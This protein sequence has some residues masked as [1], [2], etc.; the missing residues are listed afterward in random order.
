MPTQFQKNHQDFWKDRVFV[1]D[2]VLC[3]EAKSARQLLAGQKDPVCS[4]RESP[5]ALLAWTHPAG[6][7]SARAT[8]G[9][10]VPLPAHAFERS[11]IWTPALACFVVVMRCCCAFPLSAVRCTAA[12]RLF[13]TRSTSSVCLNLT[14]FSVIKINIKSLKD[15]KTF[16][17]D[18]QPTLGL[19]LGLGF[20]VGQVTRTLTLLLIYSLNSFV[21]R[22]VFHL[23]KR[24]RFKR[25]LR[26]NELSD[27]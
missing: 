25:I 27:I 5:P 23:K 10:H 22:F 14:I 6:T 11:R 19:G 1:L 16:S 18:V 20:Q 21:R 24:F 2:L 9:K 12:S 13:Y 17:I 15:R 3:G 8:A 7:A 26:T 4:A